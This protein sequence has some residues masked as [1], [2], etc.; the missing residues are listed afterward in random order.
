MSNQKIKSI[1]LRKDV[2]DLNLYQPSNLYDPSKLY[3]IEFAKSYIKTISTEKWNEATERMKNIYPNIQIP[4]NK[5]FRV[6]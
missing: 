6:S 2:G 5:R 4:I 3:L 1:T